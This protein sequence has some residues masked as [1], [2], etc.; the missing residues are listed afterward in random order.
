MRHLIDE[1]NTISLETIEAYY[2]FIYDYQTCE[3]KNIK[4]D[5]E[6][7]ELYKQVLQRFIDQ[8]IFDKAEEKFSLLKSPNIHQRKFLQLNSL[9]YYFDEMYEQNEFKILNDMIWKIVDIAV[10]QEEVEEFQSYQFQILALFQMS[11]YQ[12][13]ADQYQVAQSFLQDTL[14]QIQKCHKLIEQQKDFQTIE[15]IETQNEWVFQM[16]VKTLRL[17]TSNYKQQGQREKCM[18]YYNKV[19]NLIK[20]YEG[21]S[22]EYVLTIYNL[23]NALGFINTYRQI[24]LIEEACNNI[25]IDKKFVLLKLQRIRFLYEIDQLNEKEYNYMI[26]LQENMP[27][28]DDNFQTVFRSDMLLYAI[29]LKQYSEIKKQIDL[30]FSYITTISDQQLQQLVYR[31]KQLNDEFLDKKKNHAKEVYDK[32][33]LYYQEKAQPFIEQVQKQ[34]SENYLTLS[35]GH[36]N[37]IN[38]NMLNILRDY[39]YCSLYGRDHTLI[40]DVLE[41]T[42]KLFQINPN[43]RESILFLFQNLNQTNDIPHEVKLLLRKYIQQLEQTIQQ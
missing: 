9:I 3:R 2:K 28:I 36:Q 5:Q 22:K 35:L 29:N 30:M 41:R 42:F 23:N 32:T 4:V 21:M 1:N 25:K 37:E 14:V 38:R 43:Y 7:T 16:E 8:T 20:D 6:T 33:M 40:R 19:L 26:R 10:E 15:L 11:F 31:R 34:F 24:Q 12:Q 18:E 39:L 17:L 27:I 13:I